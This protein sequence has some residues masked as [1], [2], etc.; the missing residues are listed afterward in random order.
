MSFAYAEWSLP[1]FLG[2]VC[3]VITADEFRQRREAVMLSQAALGQRAGVTDETVRN[4][5]KGLGGTTSKRKILDALAAEERRR[6]DVGPDR[7]SPSI[8]T[9]GDRGEGWM[10]GEKQAVIDGLAE[11]G[12]LITKMLEA[13]QGD[14]SEGEK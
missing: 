8:T 12:A 13:L 9:A 5:E 7:E 11:M 14:D 4:V 3:R 2:N 10:P 1:N 6:A